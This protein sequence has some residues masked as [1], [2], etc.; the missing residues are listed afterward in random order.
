MPLV[1]Q[2]ILPI[3]HFSFGNN[4]KS[5][6]IKPDNAEC[7][8]SVMSFQGVVSHMILDLCRSDQ[9]PYSGQSGQ[10]RRI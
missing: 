6:G 10:I 5:L 9:E 3:A 1:F 8:G 2:N 4:Q 7:S